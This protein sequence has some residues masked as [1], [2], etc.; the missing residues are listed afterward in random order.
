MKRV[1]ILGSTGSI[2]ESAL[3]VVRA[4]PGRF[5]ITGLAAASNYRKLLKQ[6]AEFGVRQVAV[7]D[8]AA[9]QACRK[10]APRGITV[11]S[12]EDGLETLASASADIVLCSVVGLAGLRP[13]IAA[14]RAGRDIALATKEVLVAAGEI[15]RPMCARSGARLL[16][17]DS[18]H[19]AI[20]QCLV[21]AGERRVG[22]ADIPVKEIRRL[23]LTA[24]GG[25]FGNRPGVDLKRVTV[26]EALRHPRWTMGRKV[27][28][29]S[30]TLM[31]K[32]LEV[33]EARWLFGVPI[34]RID[35]V[36]H[37][38]SIVH[39]MVEFV[40]GSILAQMS[41][42]D[43]R[44]AIQYA[45]TCPE[46]AASGLPALDLARIGKLHFREPNLRRFPCL[47][48][49]REAAETGGTMPAVLN[50]ANEVAV[51]LFLEGRVK[52]PGI[53][54]TVEH[55]MQRHAPKMKPALGDIVEA[56]K[57]SRATALAFSRKRKTGL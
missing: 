39:S 33:I 16:P 30:A 7:V 44:F 50:G 56:D 1:V 45:L 53:W 23:I 27:T 12:G 51:R 41:V 31:N 2:G 37:P 3:Q 48:L 5:A 40:D 47:R 25:P 22:A 57:W 52:F 21:G 13:V 38:E 35:L 11:L 17:V 49:S 34:D 18:E 20:F 54:H 19:S 42:P 14:A 26:H 43:M 9:A 6:A 15:V 24:S 29:D 55:V 8:R 28:V 10:A 32:G 4:L 36:V 46:H